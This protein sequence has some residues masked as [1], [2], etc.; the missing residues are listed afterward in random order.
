MPGD[1]SISHRALLLSS[2]VEGEVQIEGLLKAGDTLSTACCLE[3][4]GVQFEGDWDRLRVKGRGLQGF[5]EPENIL[6][7]GNSGTTARL[8]TGLLAGQSFAS[9]LHG[10]ASLRKRPMDRVTVPLRQMGAFIEGR[11]NGRML[12]LFIRGGELRSIC[13]PLPVPSAQVK[14]AVLLAGL[15]AE[16]TTEVKETH[17]SR[18]HTERMLQHLGAKISKDKNS[19]RVQGGQKLNGEYIKVPG[20]ISSAI[21]LLTAAVLA[22]E[23][24]LLL[25]EIG[26]NPTR[27]GAVHVLQEMGAQIELFNHRQHSGEPVADIRAR[28]GVPLK[29]VRIAEERVPSLVDEVPVLA[30][31]ALFAQGQT[32]FRGAGELRVKETDRLHALSQELS[33]MGAAVEELPE[34][35]IIQGKAGLQGAKCHSHGD[36]RIAMALCIAALFAE[37]ET[38]IQEA[39]CVDISFPGYFD[40]LEKLTFI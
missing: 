15:L 20:D 19:C 10:D 6:D 30:V 23:G 17:P 16:D 32:E 35:L 13:Y 39:E 14:S 29:G 26:V 21:F 36:H 1:K 25:E 37:G 31:A 5:A 24:E 11:Q 9:V 7:A 3:S 40:S 34:G 12:P 28:G 18:D 4:L 38:L 27:M 33:R 8:L 2:L 22:P